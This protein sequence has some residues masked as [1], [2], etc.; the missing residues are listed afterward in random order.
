MEVACVLIPESEL[1]AAGEARR[2]PREDVWEDELRALE[3]IGAGVESERPGEAFFA[4]GGL[5][6]IHGGRRAGVVEAALGAVDLAARIGIAP[7]RFAALSAARAGVG[8]VPPQRLHELLDP[9][10][11]ATLVPRLGLG[12]REGEDFAETLRRLG[13]GTLGAL[14]AL[15]PSRVADR[16]GPPGLAALRLAR[17]EEPPLC[18]RRP[19]EELAAEI[20]LPEGTAGEQLDRALELLVDRFLAS[21]QRKGRTLLG[22]RLGALLADGDSWSVEQGLGRPPPPE[23]P[24][25]MVRAPPPAYRPSPAVPPRSRA[26][27][28]GPPAGEQMEISARA[29]DP[30]LHRLG[31]AA[32]QV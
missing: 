3:G 32:R 5:R 13:V 23:R 20:E 14:T 24:L 27:S 15:S 22:L 7:T 18:P 1:R 26:L 30:R 10:P 16:F 9:L 25:R 8:P 2:L 4:V 29:H 6:G 17:G 28:T 19:R 12:E 11:V 31:D 21:P